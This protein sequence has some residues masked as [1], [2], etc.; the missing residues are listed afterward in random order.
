M[1]TKSGSASSGREQELVAALQALHLQAGRPSARAIAAAV[2][3]VSHTT[4][5]EAL[6]GKRIPSWPILQRIINHLDGDESEILTLWNAAI[7]SASDSARTQSRDDD[8]P[9]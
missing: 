2:G 6:S 9:T 8:F 7:G 4:V 3:N 1:S 5:A